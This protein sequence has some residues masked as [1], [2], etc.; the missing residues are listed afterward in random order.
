MLVEGAAWSGRAARSLRAFVEA[1]CQDEK[2]RRLLEIDPATALREWQWESDVVP[3]LLSPPMSAVSVC[4]DDASLL[5]PIA[6]RTETDKALL[7][8]TQLRLLLA[9]AKPLALIH[10]S[11]QSLTALATWMRARGY[12]TLLGPHEF[13]PQ[14]DSCKG[15]Y[16]NRMTKVTSARAGSGAWRGLL[17]APD[18]QTVLM[19]WLCQLFGWESFLG[20][21]LGYPSCCCKAFEDR[22]PIAASN[23]EGDVGLMLLKESESRPEAAPA[24]HNL[25]WTTN[26][27]SRYFGWEIIQHFPC[28]LDCP[29]TTNLAR[30]YFAVLT[31]Y[32]P[33]E[34][35]EILRNLAS[36]L[37]VIP[38]HGYSLFRGG[39]VVREDTGTSLI[40]DPEQV[41]IIGMGS[42]FTDEIVSSSRLTTGINGG[43]KIAGGDV[44]GCLLDVSLDEAV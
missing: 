41:Q 23:H 3:A 19:A 44:P 12:Y 4:I 26:I 25:S 30:R 1:A 7:R 43:W 9:G 28:R 40:Y 38:N 14:H 17:V 34:A 20:R 18:E 22:W 21:L 32:W 2:L 36:P 6:W 39:R 42:M 13:L 27:F 5:G 16:S 35:Q 31:H 24:V 11:E 8:Q 29:A 15:G 33:A 37:L 10:G